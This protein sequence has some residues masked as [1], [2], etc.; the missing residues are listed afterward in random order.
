MQIK[1]L[2]YEKCGKFL[3]NKPISFFIIYNSDNRDR[4]IQ[5]LRGARY[6][7]YSWD[8]YKRLKKLKIY[9]KLISTTFLAYLFVAN[10]TAQKLLTT[11]PTIEPT[12]R[13]ACNRASTLSR[14]KLLQSPFILLLLKMCT[15]FKKNLAN[16]L[17]IAYS[18]SINFQQRETFLQV[19]KQALE[20][21]ISKLYTYYLSKT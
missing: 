9:I 8:F 14:K 5:K 20:L 15:N 4:N 13:T 17:L 2:R 21:E 16:T 18:S 19:L 7:S 11:T 6:Q 1:I 12:P 3:L 10:G